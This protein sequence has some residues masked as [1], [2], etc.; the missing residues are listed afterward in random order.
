MQKIYKRNY[1]DGRFASWDVLS[2]RQRIDDRN[3]RIIAFV[4]VACLVFLIG[5]GVRSL[6][7]AVIAKAHET[8]NGVV[9]HQNMLYER[10]RAVS[11]PILPHIAEAEEAVDVES[12]KDEVV[13]KLR[14]GESAG[15][16]S[17]PDKIF[18]T[19]DPAASMKK[20]CAR[21]G[22]IM[23]LEC[24]SFGEFQTKIGTVQMWQRML[25]GEALNDREAMDLALDT[26]R[27]R[28]FVKRVI[29]ELP[30]GE[31]WHWS[32]AI[33]NKAWFNEHI[34]RIRNLTK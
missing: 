3:G 5:L 34:T 2:R 32:Y 14:V 10:A 9:S 13:E 23:P 24:S 20:Q 16:I 11:A 15:H 22:G 33:H 26:E 25:G 30:A 18:Q 12:L 7:L 6:S 27:M 4:I 1:N 19:Y 21:A 8:W 29:F 17:T 31:V 28:D